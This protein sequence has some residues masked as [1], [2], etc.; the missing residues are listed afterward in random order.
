VLEKCG[1]RFIREELIDDHPAKTYEI[2]RS[3]Y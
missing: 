2:S 3:Y 1:M